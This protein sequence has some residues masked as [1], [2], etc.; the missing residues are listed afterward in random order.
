ME[1]VPVF[2]DWLAKR[3]ALRAALAA[4]EPNLHHAGPLH[5]VPGAVTE[6]DSLPARVAARSV[7]LS[8]AGEVEPR[9]LFELA[10]DPLDQYA[11][12]WELGGGSPV[13]DPGRDWGDQDPLRCKEAMF[14]PDG[15]MWRWCER[16]GLPTWGDIPDGLYEADDE[17]LFRHVLGHVWAMSE[18]ALTLFTWRVDPFRPAAPS[19][20]GQ[21][22]ELAWFRHETELGLAAPL[23]LPVQWW[24][25]QWEDRASATKRILAEL[26]R[27]VRFELGRIEIEALRVA[28]APPAKR[29]GLEH[30]AWL[31]RY[32]FRHE[33]FSEIAATVHRG[34]QTVADGVRDAAALVGLPL[35]EPTPAGRPR[36]GG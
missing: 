29:T 8:I 24:D 21:F 2:P 7:F 5:P 26:G 34:R 13:A 23:S 9:L 36:R 28:A 6:P 25:P 1:D 17:T 35:R 33:S 20:F 19:S 12:A 22:L 27:V 10:G 18:V 11:A 14:D 31:A 32:H 4:R 30:L 15:A 3:D 16:W